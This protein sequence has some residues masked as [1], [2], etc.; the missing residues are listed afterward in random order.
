LTVLVALFAISSFTIDGFASSANIKSMLVFAAFL[1]LASVGRPW[2][3]CSAG[4]TSRSLHHR[5]LE[6]RAALPHRPSAFHR[7]S[8]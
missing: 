6:R 3:P 8:P 2:S 4:W 5:R 1:G 7:G